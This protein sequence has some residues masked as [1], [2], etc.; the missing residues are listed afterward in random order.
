MKQLTKVIPC[1]VTI[2]LLS[3]CGLAGQQPQQT[4][5]PAT[6]PD[7]IGEWKQTNSNSDDSWQAATI[8]NDTIEIYWV[9]DDG[10]TKALYWAGTFAAPETADEPYSWE[11]ENDKEKTGMALLASGDDIKKFTYNDGVISYDVS[12]MGVTQQIKLER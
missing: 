11:S 5:E 9:S 7:L 10:N 1:I 4:E 2:L 6:P 3:A 12:A 8:S